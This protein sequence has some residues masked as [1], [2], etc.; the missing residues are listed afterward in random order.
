M[1]AKICRLHGRPQE[2]HLCCDGVSCDSEGWTRA[3]TR[4]FTS[5]IDVLSVTIS[6]RRKK[7]MSK[8]TDCIVLRP[9][10]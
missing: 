4:Q 8:K 3:E 6:Q 7:R 5:F 2:L 1:D 9:Q 10:S